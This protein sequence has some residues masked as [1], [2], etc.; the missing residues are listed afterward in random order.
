MTTVKRSSSIRDKH[1][2][3]IARDKPGC[4]ICGKAIDY[5]LPHLDPMAYVVDHVKPLAKGGPDT[6][7]N[8]KAAHRECNSKKRARLIAPIVRRSGSLD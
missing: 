3:R 2:A 7:D 1:R 5:S 6:L 8:K 4:H